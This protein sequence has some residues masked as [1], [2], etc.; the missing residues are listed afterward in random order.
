MKKILTLFA[1]GTLLS[2][3]QGAFAWTY[4]GLQSL[5]P[6]TGFRNCNPCKVERCKKPKLTKCEKLQGV[7]IQ[8]GVPCGCAAPVQIE[9]QAAM[10]IIIETPAPK[11]SMP[12]VIEMPSYTRQILQDPCVDCHRAF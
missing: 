8:R 4:D 10:P 9:T 6:F 7:K 2:L 12:V 3:G 5:N 11:H 1:L